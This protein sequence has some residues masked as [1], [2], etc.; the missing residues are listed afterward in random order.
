MMRIFAI[1]NETVGRNV[2]QAVDNLEGKFVK[3]MDNKIGE[4]KIDLKLIS[5]ADAKGTSAA[6]SAM[7]DKMRDMEN[8]LR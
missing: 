1:Q 8:K 4:A 3:V 6:V 5:N 7:T 2:T